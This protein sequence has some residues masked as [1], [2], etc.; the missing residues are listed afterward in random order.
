MIGQEAVDLEFGEFPTAKDYIEAGACIADAQD[1]EMHGFVMHNLPDDPYAAF[2]NL[3]PFFNAAGFVM[4]TNTECYRY[5]RQGPSDDFEP[6][7]DRAPEPKG[8]VTTALHMFFNQAGAA[9]GTFLVPTA[10]RMG[11]RDKYVS[12]HAQNLLEKN[13]TDPWLFEL[14]AY[15]ASLAV[16]SLAVFRVGGQRPLAHLFRTVGKKTRVSYVNQAD[17]SGI[18]Y[19]D[20]LKN[21]LDAANAGRA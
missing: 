13:K 4:R 3:K 8:P 17:I 9:H 21:G 10:Y 20:L 15:T 18:K 2:N 12:Q 11:V 7:M 5:V 19:Y 6:H 16:G 1:P 14:K